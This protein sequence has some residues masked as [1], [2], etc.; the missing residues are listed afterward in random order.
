[1][2]GCG[3]SRWIEEGRKINSSVEGRWVLHSCAAR[4]RGVCSM[5]KEWMDVSWGGRR[6]IVRWR[7]CMVSY[8]LCCSFGVKVDLQ[9]NWLSELL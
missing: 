4:S 2:V 3:T 7:G 6:K 8:A 9:M 1:M 5:G